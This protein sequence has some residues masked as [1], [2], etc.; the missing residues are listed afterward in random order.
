[1]LP[2]GV[3]QMSPSPRPVTGQATSQVRDRR[4]PFTANP[5]A[6][7]GGREGGKRSPAD[8]G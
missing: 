7:P 2:G 6:F 1:M 5:Q 4:W 3:A 8:L